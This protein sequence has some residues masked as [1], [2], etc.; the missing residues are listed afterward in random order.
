MSPYD[1]PLLALLRLTLE[2]ISLAA[3][4]FDK[5]L[6]GFIAIA[7]ALAIFSTPGDKNFVLIKVP[8]PVRAMIEVVVFVGAAEA[9][10]NQLG[11]LWAAG[12]GLVV[13]GYLYLARD[14]MLWLLRGA[15][16]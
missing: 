11:L 12:F 15:P 16:I 6:L 9:I 2:I 10:A 7:I 13:I 14:R 5:G 3:I 8:G 4:L 1:R